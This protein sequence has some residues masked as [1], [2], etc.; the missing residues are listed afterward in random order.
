MHPTHPGPHA[1]GRVADCVLVD[2]RGELA[3][4]GFDGVGAGE[5]AAVEL[6]EGGEGVGWIGGAGADVEVE[7]DGE[8]EE[9]EEG[10][11]C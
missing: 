4:P 11:G 5:R 10:V 6:G 3:D 1:L 9:E 2:E 8:G 7:G